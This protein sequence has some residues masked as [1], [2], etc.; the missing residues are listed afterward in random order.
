M[1]AATI[2]TLVAVSLFT[3]T[4]ALAQSPAKKKR[5]KAEP[6]LV[7]S[8]EP[9]PQLP[10]EP[11]S[12]APAPVVAAPEPAVKDVPATAA[13]ETEMPAGTGF[14][15][16]M[17]S[18]PTVL[19][20][21]IAEG[22]AVGGVLATFNLRLGGYVTPHVGIL[23]GLQGGYGALLDGCSGLCDKAFSY[24]IP[25]VVQYAF[26]DRRRGAYVD[27]GLAFVS[28]YSASTN[29]P[30]A[31]EKIEMS[32]PVDIKLGAGYRFGLKNTTNKAEAQALDLRF[33][34]DFG[35]FKK[36]S[37]QTTVG[38]VEGDIV[39]ARQ[40]SHYAI[41]LSVGYQFAP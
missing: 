5:K 10:P 3:S 37:Y 39:D 18:G 33:G 20:G 41:G 38:S 16:G 34:L 8:A 35:K 14:V 28:T 13:E 25:V 31:A 17:S 29:K 32:S 21:Q 36:L 40:A 6:V 19:A 26:R 1:R 30:G 7:A 9:L 27:A 4:V 15:V 12:A 22:L 2:A 11:V 24:Q 23:A